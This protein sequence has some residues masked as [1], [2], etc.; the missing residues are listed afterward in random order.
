MFFV[1]KPISFVIK[2]TNSRRQINK[3]SK[4]LFSIDK[5]DV[6]PVISEE[7]EDPFSKDLSSWTATG[8]VLDSWTATGQVLDSWTATGHLQIT[9]FDKI[10]HISGLEMNF[11]CISIFPKHA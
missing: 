4:D 9:T 8:Q 7:K 3:F 6:I 1:E 10:S 2:D 11:E 5:E